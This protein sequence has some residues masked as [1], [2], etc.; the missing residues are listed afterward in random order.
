MRVPKS[1]KLNI[2]LLFSMTHFGNPPGMVPEQVVHIFLRAQNWILN[3][4]FSGAEY[5]TMIS[6]K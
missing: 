5:K 1:I 2:I 4:Y 6:L 3:P